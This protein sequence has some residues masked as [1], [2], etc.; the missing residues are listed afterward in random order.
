MSRGHE[1]DT[2]DDQQNDQSVPECTCYPSGW[3][4]DTY[5]GPQPWCD[6]HGLPS[7]A[8][9]QG[10]AEGRRQLMDVVQ[11][12]VNAHRWGEDDPLQF[13]DELLQALR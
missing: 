6:V 1:G 7:A 10:Q 13:R 4:Y 2:M 5:E 11:F 12:M 8:W 9:E 3:T